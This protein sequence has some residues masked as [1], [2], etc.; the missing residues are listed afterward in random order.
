MRSE[1]LG[2]ILD[3][4]LFSQDRTVT[5]GD[6]EAAAN[7]TDA[8]FRIGTGLHRLALAIENRTEAIRE[9]EEV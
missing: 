1:E 8:L 9:A 4:I 5:V 3:R 2:A 7:I 6:H